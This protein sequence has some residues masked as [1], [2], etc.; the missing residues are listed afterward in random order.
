MLDDAKDNIS[1]RQFGGIPGSSPVLALLEML[2]NWYLALDNPDT[3]IRVIFLDFTKAFDLIDH[4]LLISDFQTIGVRTALLPWLASY[5]SQRQ[6]RV[7]FDGVLSNFLTINAG[8]PQGSK[9][10]PFS[11][12]AKINGL[13]D[14]AVTDNSTNKESV[15]MFI[16]DTT[17]SE[18]LNLTNYKSHQPIGNME[19]NINRISTFCS[20]Q[21]MVLN[22]KKT[23]EMIF[24]F[25]VNKTTINSISLNDL[26]IERV[27]SFKLLGIWLDDNLKW[28]SN[29]D[30][31]VKKA[32]KRLYFL[33]VLKRYGAPT[34]DLLRFYCSVIRSILEYGD[35]L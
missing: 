8:V 18:I 15:S 26:E 10:G 14:V 3:G 17:L 24:D 29:T 11:F 23:K 34:Q 7:N 22:T 6:Q 27:S 19:L 28:N 25:R 16:D 5:L 9:I 13:P 31:I 30:Y 2:H 12:I 21:R 35:V 4:N 33:K 32:R 20:D 1:T